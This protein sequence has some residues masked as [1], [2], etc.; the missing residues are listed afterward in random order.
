MNKIKYLGNLALAP[1]YFMLVFGFGVISAAKNA[2]LETA[3]AISTT[4]RMYK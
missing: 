2:F 1:L 3:D 4:K